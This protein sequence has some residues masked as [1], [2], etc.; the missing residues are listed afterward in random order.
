MN[1]YYIKSKN[2]FA[3]SRNSLGNDIY[4]NGK[5]LKIHNVWFRTDYWVMIRMMIRRMVLA[6]LNTILSKSAKRNLKN[7]V[8]KINWMF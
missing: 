7:I 5:W 3:R 8:L 1:Y 2:L 6:V 4:Q